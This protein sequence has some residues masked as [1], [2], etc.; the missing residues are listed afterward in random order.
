[1]IRMDGDGYKYLHDVENNGRWC[2]LC[3]DICYAN[4][5]F[6]LQNATQFPF[7]A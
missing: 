3:V 4:T 2:C 7:F 1:M 5:N 6:A